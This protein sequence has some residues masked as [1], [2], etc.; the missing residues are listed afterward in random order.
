MSLGLVG[1]AM[2]IHEEPL[3]GTNGRSYPFVT[4]MYLKHNGSWQIMD[5]EGDLTYTKK[6][7]RGERCAHSDDAR[8]TVGQDARRLGE[9]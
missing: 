8:L 7:S 2:P 4:W 6:L 5:E 1:E 9:H 3:W